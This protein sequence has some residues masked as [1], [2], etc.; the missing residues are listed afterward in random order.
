MKYKD[1]RDAKRKYKQALLATVATMTLGV[2]T[3]GSTASA[4]AE[5]KTET[6]QEQATTDSLGAGG[7]ATLEEQWKE[8]AKE[9]G[10]HH[11]PSLNAKGVADLLS[12]GAFSVY[13][14]AHSN[15][16][17]F[18]NTF[19]T[20]SM[21]ISEYFPYGKLVI[22]PLI[23]LLWPETVSDKNNQFES[24]IQEMSSLMD[25][26][27]EDF[28]L[29]TIKRQIE[30]LKKEMQAF[31]RL[32]NSQILTEGFYSAGSPEESARTKAEH[33]QAKFHELISLCQKDKLSEAELPL[34][35]KIANIH[36]LFLDFMDKNWNKSKLQIDQKSFDALYAND[37]KN[38]AQTYAQHIHDTFILSNQKIDKKLSDIEKQQGDHKATLEWLRNKLANLAH[39]KE[40]KEKG[41]TGSSNRSLATVKKE[42]DAFEKKYDN[43]KNLLNKKNTYQASTVADTGFH[44]AS[45]KWKKENKKWY[46]LNIH[47]DKQTGWVLSWNS[48][49]YYLNPEKTDIK[50]SAGVTFKPG[51]MV[52][53]K[54]DIKGK[55]YFFKP[56]TGEMVTGWAHD[57]D[58]SYYV[59]PYDGF[60]NLNDVAFKEGELVTGWIQPPEG[61]TYYLSPTDG[62]KNY[63]D[64]VFNKGEMM[65]GWVA[66]AHD[67]KSTNTNPATYGG[68]WYYF[69]DNN[70][71][72]FKKILG[73]MLHDEY[74]TTKDG[75]WWINKNGTKQ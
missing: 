54:I 39:D 58:K 68:A 46:F 35:T 20:L 45:G 48:N 9:L 7:G 2:S 61:N 73:R 50:N 31:E 60:K 38:A 34:Y 63:A 32:V 57:G 26:K 37:I 6:Q 10:D 3:L 8:M 52:T 18:N 11:S 4:F 1:R 30:A 71:S 29:A 22:S 40:L 24:L 17:N 44:A 36:L 13:K 28:D 67:G 66:V 49:Y 51:E 15:K 25:Q 23:G 70:N 55:T 33:L 19:R 42:H 5:E 65:T 12:K 43:Y 16:G 14:D 74:V 59:S 69:D 75:T 27:I 62:S 56:E 47:G 64:V 21:G 53:G 41:K 72:K